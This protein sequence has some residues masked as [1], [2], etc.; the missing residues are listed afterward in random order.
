MS[1]GHEQ[2]N[3]QFFRQAIFSS[4]SVSGRIKGSDVDPK[5]LP[6]N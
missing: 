6:E 2:E 4:P 5:R 3:N 1:R